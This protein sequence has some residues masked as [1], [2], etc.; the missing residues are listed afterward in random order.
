MAFLTKTILNKMQNSSN[1][2]N[3]IIKAALEAKFVG[4][5]VSPVVDVINATPNPIVA[6]EILL[7]LYVQ[8]VLPEILPDTKTEVN[9]KIIDYDRFK[10]EVKYSYNSREAVEVWVKKED[11]ESNNLPDY[12]SE[13][14]LKGYYASDVCKKVFLPEEEFRKLYTQVYIYGKVSETTKT[15][16]TSN[17]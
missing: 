6:A 7:G 15:S 11:K 2:M 14:L 17:Y 16:T 8:P 4:V 1:K 13:N 5:D 9:R 12:K 10:N 3:K